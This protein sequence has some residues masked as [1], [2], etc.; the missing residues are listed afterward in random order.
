[1]SMN[2]SLIFVISFCVGIVIGLTGMG[3]GSLLSPFLIFG[4]GIQ[5]LTAVG[6][7]IAVSAITKAF[8]ALQ[9][10]R[11]KSVDLSLV[12]Y[13]TVGS[14]PGCGIAAVLIRW[15][16]GHSQRAADIFI[17]RLLAFVLFLAALSLVYD[18]IW[19]KKRL[20]LRRE[21]KWVRG[22]L[23]F[24]G[25]LIGILVTLTSAGSGTLLV[26]FLTLFFP[27][28]PPWMV[29]G[30]DLFHAFLL[31][32]VAATFHFWAGNVDATLMVLMLAGSVPG[33]VLGSHLTIRIP[34]WALQGSLAAMLLFSVIKL[35]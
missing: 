2:E 34:V 27:L 30:S 28:L 24:G 16:Q 25:F 20:P 19:R 14:I 21:H 11:Q 23:V 5:P 18:L 3:S 29:V 1:M 15:L 13:L 7:N 26:A 33:A 32:V 4:L 31:S 8:G 22:S 12:G 10:L 17:I 6:T 9:H 35:L